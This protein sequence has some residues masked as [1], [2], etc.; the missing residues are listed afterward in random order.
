VLKIEVF[1]NAALNIVFAIPEADVKRENV[2]LTINKAMT[3]SKE[4]A[5]AY[6]LFD[7]RNCKAGQTIIDGFTDMAG[8]GANFGVPDNYVI[9][10]L[11]N[12]E[13]YPIDRA[14]F[15]ESV[16]NTL[17][18]PAYRM[19]MDYQLAIDWLQSFQ[20]KRN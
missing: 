8:F 19:F 11:F 9:A 3:L 2:L 20:L 14:K 15:I 4:L 1:H 16:T 17:P 18:N 10:V 6:V 5:C 12:A 13:K 7:I